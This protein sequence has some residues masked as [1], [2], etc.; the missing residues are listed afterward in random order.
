[1]EDD[2][3]EIAARNR[4]RAE[5]VIADTGL[6]DSWRSVGAEPRLVGSLAMGLLMKHRDIDFHIYSSPL[7]LS[8]SFKAMSMIAA[9]PSI[10]R[11]ECRN[12]TDT[13]EKCVE[14]HAWYE[15]K[16]C[17]T[18]QIDMI[19]ILKGSR[20]DGYFERMASWIRA[21]L[22]EEIRRT[23]LKLKYLTPETEH[24]MGVEYYQAVLEGGVRDMR[25]FRLWREKH[26]VSGI[27]EWMP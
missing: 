9:N 21:L 3:L 1:M 11:I 25:E 8:D 24:I 7:K 20:Y 6:A 19:H 12:M 2:F 27:V 22:T 26:P 16:E 15:D 5:E 23:I 17:E 18:W 14:W 4:K 13:D 10:V